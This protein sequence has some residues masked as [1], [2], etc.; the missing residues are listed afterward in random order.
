MLYARSY[1]RINATLFKHKME[2]C[3]EHTVSRLKLCC[4]CSFLQWLVSS[5]S[6]QIAAQTIRNIAVFGLHSSGTHQM[7]IKMLSGDYKHKSKTESEREKHLNK[8]VLILFLNFPLMK[9]TL[10]FLIEIRLFSGTFYPGRL[11]LH[12]IQSAC[13]KIST[14]PAEILWRAAS[15]LP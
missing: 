9:E 5:F 1:L 6:A 8:I 3:A 14:S 7:S 4:L 13:I 10:G 15:A 12:R 11:M 2:K